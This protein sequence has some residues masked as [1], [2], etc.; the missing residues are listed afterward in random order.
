MFDIVL[1]PKEEITQLT[2]ELN[3]ECKQAVLMVKYAVNQVLTEKKLQQYLINEEAAAALLLENG[4]YDRNH[5]L[6]IDNGTGEK[7]TYTLEMLLAKYE[8][9]VLNQSVFARVTDKVLF[10]WF[11]ESVGLNQ[12][13]ADNET[14]LTELVKED[15]LERLNLHASFMAETKEL[16][17]ADMALEMLITTFIEQAKANQLDNFLE[18]IELAREEFVCDSKIA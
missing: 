11:K 9:E 10:T 7:E 18:V 2:L 14:D 12:L 3:A 13:K 5:M 4:Y 15:L 6:S 17:N 16:E 1:K 8:R